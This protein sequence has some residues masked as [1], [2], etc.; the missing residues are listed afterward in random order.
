MATT[1][2]KTI[3]S[4]I[5]HMSKNPALLCR[6]TMSFTS[7][8][9]QLYSCTQEGHII[10][11]CKTTVAAIPVSPQKIHAKTDVKVIPT[12]K[13]DMNTEEYINTITEIE[14]VAKSIG[15]KKADGDGRI[16]SAIKEP[17]FLNEMKRILLEST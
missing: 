15:V 12:V 16:D 3:Q 1:L 10:S 14:S 8:K 5:S 6:D 7:M 4:S 17:L 11:S 2:S 13:V 9:K